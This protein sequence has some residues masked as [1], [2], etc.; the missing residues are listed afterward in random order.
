M[1]MKNI[2]FIFTDQM[3]KFALNCMGTDDII[4]PNL[5][6]LASQGVLF[7]NAYSNCPICTP[8]R[9]NLFTGL[10][11]SQTNTLENE[12]SIPDSCYTL[13]DALNAGGYTTS[14]VG[15][16]HIGDSGNKPIP[17][18]KRGGFQHFIG[19]QCYNGFQDNV[20]FY[21]EEGSETRFEKHRTDVTTDLAIKRLNEIKDDKF[22]MFVSYQAPHYPVQPD[23]E[24][25]N[26]YKG[27]TIK[28]RF[29]CL[30]I[31]PYTR[32]FSPPSPWPPDDCKNYIKYGNNL[33]EYLR[34]YYAMITQIDANVGRLLEELERIGKRENT[35][36]IFTSD[37]G[38]MQGA[39]GKKNKCLPYE[40]SSGIPL[41]VSMPGALQNGSKCDALV[42]GI[43]FYPSM[44]DYADIKGQNALP[45][46]S[47]MPLLSNTNSSERSVFSE[48]PDWKMIRQGDFKLVVATEGLRPKKFFNLKNDPFEMNNLVDDTIY[49]SK[50]S[51]LRTD[52]ED[53]Y[54]YVKKNKKK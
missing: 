6:K 39:H 47:F 29:N 12:S 49:Q 46:R 4:T 25:A 11:S 53:W 19:Y 38:D 5:D 26:L 17:E 42:S 35:V 32:T 44:L 22:A 16:W 48:M 37:H 21:D 1:T 50:I 54:K 27:K 43:D 40:E 3:H 9:I 33:D 45:G 20:C 2:L 31:D 23:A 41:I 8:F 28:R 14:Y 36:V 13:A 34:L 18:N 52:V 10:Y 30:D 24:Y 51:Q 15:K 7:T